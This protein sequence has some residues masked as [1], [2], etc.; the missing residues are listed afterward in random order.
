MDVLNMQ[1]ERQNGLLY[2][3]AGFLL[4]ALLPLAVFLAERV[5]LIS[6]VINGKHYVL[7]LFAV[8]VNLIAMRFAFRGGRHALFKGLLIATFLF[9]LLIFMYRV[10]A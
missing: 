9:S 10:P 2:T 4:G 5:L 3:L 8:A 6:P 1:P 7:Y